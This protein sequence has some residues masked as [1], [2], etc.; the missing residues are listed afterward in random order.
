MKRR[1]QGQQH[2][3]LLTWLLDDLHQ[4]VFPVSAQ[5]PFKFSGYRTSCCMKMWALTCLLARIPLNGLC[6]PMTTVQTWHYNLMEKSASWTTVIPFLSPF[7]AAWTNFCYTLL[8]QRTASP[9][10]F[11]VI[12]TCPVNRLYLRLYSL[13]ESDKKL[14]ST[15]SGLLT[16]KST[17]V[18]RFLTEE[19][20]C[21]LRYKHLLL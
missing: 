13:G 14:K 2:L 12:L 17:F 16:V 8:L 4:D 6:T 20:P 15:F 19:G 1:W 10:Y 7:Q 21:P 11:L 3:T 5:F 9:A 18:T